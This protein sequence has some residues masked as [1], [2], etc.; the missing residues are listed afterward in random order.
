MTQ[1]P[2]QAPTTTEGMG[3][4]PNPE[5]PAAPAT[6]GT[7]T[8]TNLDTATL[9]K[10]VSE[11]RAENAK[12]RV[13]NKEL[14]TQVEQFRQSQLTEEQKRQAE[15]EATKSA[16]E[17]ATKQRDQL[18]IELAVTREA[19]RLGIVDPEAAQLLIANQITLEDG[20]ATNVGDLLTKLIEGRPW[21]KSAAPTVPA[22]P[23]AGSPA[24][25][26][27]A[28]VLTLEIIRNMKREELM[29]NEAAVTEFLSKQR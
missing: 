5:T 24:N 4:A 25:A 26:Q 27:K 9:Q 16:A 18:A 6:G 1:V 15:F 7:P 17:A 22:V 13:A 19:Q 3:Q 29:A 10:L 8:E 14:S 23:A 20:K 21:L 2:G 12:N 11:L 28:P